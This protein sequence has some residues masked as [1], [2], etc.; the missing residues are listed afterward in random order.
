MQKCKDD[1]DPNYR[2]KPCAINSCSCPA[3]ISAMLFA[4]S[5]L[6]LMNRL[7]ILNY[8]VYNHMSVP[9]LVS[10]LIIAWN[11]ERYLSVCLDTLLAQTHKDF[12]IVIIDNGS[13]DQEYLDELEENYFDLKLTIKK[14]NKN[15]GFA[16][17]NNIGARLARG[18]YLVLL[19]ADAFPEPDWLEQLV[20][21]AEEKPEFT[22]FASRQIQANSPDLL[23]GTGDEY[24]ITG[25]A[26]RQNYNHPSN[27]YGTESGEVFSACA[28]AAL[29]LRDD[30]IKVGGFDEDYF[31]YHED[32]DL[33]F[34]LRLAGG[35]CLYVPQAV[36]YHVGSASTSKGSDFAFYHGHRNLVWTYFKDMPSPLFWF[37]LPLHMLMNIYL[38]AVFLLREKRVVILKSKIDAFRALP[39]MLRKRKHVQQMRTVGSREIYRVLTKELLAPHWASRERNIKK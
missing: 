19:N 36:V 28:A 3:C 37:Y 11:S 13:I 32:V 27:K 26:W 17:A 8:I 23:D 9:P 2:K 12:E 30:F 25:L 15:L 34:R 22:F 1:F 33:S 18:K 16:V 6:R 39:V 20:R 7:R 24:H 38:S 21:V 5:K 29:Y 10:I 14:I 35:R 4:S 31:S